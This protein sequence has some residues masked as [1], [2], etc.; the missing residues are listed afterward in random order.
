M[1]EYL[2]KDTTL[3]DIGNAIRE[4]TKRLKTKERISNSKKRRK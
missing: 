4:I 2:I 3:T 1:A